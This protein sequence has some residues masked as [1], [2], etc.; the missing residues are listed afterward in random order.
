MK[1]LI[2]VLVPVL[3]VAAG[4]YGTGGETHSPDHSTSATASS[5]T[6]TPA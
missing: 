3:M 2:A 4:A 1:K 6:N 5:I